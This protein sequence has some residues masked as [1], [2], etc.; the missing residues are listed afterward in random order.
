MRLTYN[1]IREIFL[2]I[3]TIYFDNHSFFLVN[4]HAYHPTNF[5]V[6]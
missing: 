5:L 6:H 1:Y 3:V 4:M 2:L